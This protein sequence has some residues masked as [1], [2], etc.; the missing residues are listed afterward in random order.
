MRKTESL[1]SNLP[2]IDIRSTEG[3]S[4]IAPLIMGV[5]SER[6]VDVD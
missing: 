4:P 6:E 1:G 2:H 5:N 3:S